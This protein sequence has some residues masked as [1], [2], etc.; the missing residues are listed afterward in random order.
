[1]NK[2]IIEYVWIGGNSE[3]RSKTRVI[4]R[5]I[6]NTIN[7]IPEWNY[8]GSSTNQAEGHDSE[9]II[10]PVALYNHYNNSDRHRI[11]LCDTSFG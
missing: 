5:D 4:K 3:L 8:D 1:M 6:I 9:V 7:D 11:I 2:F 10:R